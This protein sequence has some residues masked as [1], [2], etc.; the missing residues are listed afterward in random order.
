MQ[1]LIKGTIVVKGD[2][3]RYQRKFAALGKQID[4][5]VEITA[6]HPQNGLSIKLLPDGTGQGSASGNGKSC[7]V[8]NPTALETFIL[9]C[10]ARVPKVQRPNGNA[11]KCLSVVRETK[12]QWEDLGTL[13]VLRLNEFERVEGRISVEAPAT[14]ASKGK[15]KGKQPTKGKGKKK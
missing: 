1:D 6:V 12:G 14:T 10:D 9:D 8:D 5:T 13:W 15:G 7:T 4:R 2:H 3:L 11:W